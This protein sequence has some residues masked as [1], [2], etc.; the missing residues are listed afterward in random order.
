MTCGFSSFR[1]VIQRL[2]KQHGAQKSS[3]HAD[4]ISPG[5]SSPPCASSLQ[6]TSSSSSPGSEAKST[7]SNPTSP[8]LLRRGS[9]ALKS[10]F[11][12]SEASNSPPK[13]ELTL[14]SWLEES[15]RERTE[16][17]AKR[18]LEQLHKTR[19]ANSDRVQKLIRLQ[20]SFGMQSKSINLLD[21]PERQLLF[22]G[23]LLI[24]GTWKRLILFGD[25]MVVASTQRIGNKLDLY[26][27][28]DLSPALGQPHPCRPSL[29][30]TTLEPC[31]SLLPSIYLSYLYNFLSVVM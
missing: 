16:P 19:Q 3:K 18:S 10:L 11:A 4:G 23:D 29:M 27:L 8:M 5:S 26:M 22:L 30:L 21:N 28:L 2:L 6:S 31:L 13:A 7:A 24:L 17:I 9:S 15:V 14:D 12:A 1:V 20:K 25:V